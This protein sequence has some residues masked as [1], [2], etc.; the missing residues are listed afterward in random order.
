M[1]DWIS[2]GQTKLQ[3]SKRRHVRKDGTIK[4]YE[5]LY[6]ILNK[7][8]KNFGWKKGDNLIVYIRQSDGLF[9][10]IENISLKGRLKERQASQKP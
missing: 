2:L 10:S 5:V 7:M 3:G 1:S 8:V 4:E 9:V 6:V